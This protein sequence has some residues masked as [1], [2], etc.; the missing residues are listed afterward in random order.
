LTRKASVR[1][2]EAERAELERRAAQNG[3]SLSA[4][5][6]G[7][8]TGHLKVQAVSKADPELLRQVAAIGNNLNQIA[9]RVN[10]GQ[11]AVEVLAELR[12][13]ERQLERLI[14]CT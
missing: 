9:R 13:I 10:A 5:L 7:V 6:R 4:Y 3:V 11:P 14:E 12:A 1:L 2:S 8:I